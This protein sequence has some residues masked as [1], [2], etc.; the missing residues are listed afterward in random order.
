RDNATCDGPCGL[1][2]RQKL[3]SGMR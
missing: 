1:R 3:E 2:F